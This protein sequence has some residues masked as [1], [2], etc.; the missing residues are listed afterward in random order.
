MGIHQPSASVIEQGGWQGPGADLAA[1][2]GRRIEQ[3]IGKVEPI[4]GQILLR[5]GCGFTLIDKDKTHPSFPFLRGSA[6]AQALERAL[7]AWAA[8]WLGSWRRT[9]EATERRHEQSTAL[10]DLR[11]RAGEGVGAVLA[12]RLILDGLELRRTTARTA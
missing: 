5:R 4:G 3:D 1:N 12:T 6:V 8:G 11:L 10:L 7:D 2:A 9:C